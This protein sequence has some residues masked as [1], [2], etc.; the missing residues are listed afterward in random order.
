[1]KQLTNIDE[2]SRETLESA[3]LFTNDSIGGEAKQ[4][5]ATYLSLLSLD[6]L[7]DKAK[8]YGNAL[9]QEDKSRLVPPLE[10]KKR[11]YEEQRIRVTHEA[12]P[13]AKPLPSAPKS[14]SNDPQWIVYNILLSHRNIADV[15]DIAPGCL[16]IVLEQDSDLI[17]QSIIN[18]ASKNGFTGD[19]VFNKK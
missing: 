11:N 7:R 6:E 4:R 13:H 9:F 3:I 19:L 10:L 12:V 16:G 17:R 14:T 5:M 15:V 2:C 8:S 1:M 18:I